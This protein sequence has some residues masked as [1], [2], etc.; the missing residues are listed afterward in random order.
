MSTIHEQFRE[1]FSN[2][3]SV[4]KTLPEGSAEQERVVKGYVEMYRALLEHGKIDEEI[5][6]RRV[7]M[8][9][10]F[11][12]IDREF[13]RDYAKINLD[14][15]LGITKIIALIGVFVSGVLL[16]NQGMLVPRIDEF[17]KRV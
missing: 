11:A 6:D 4:I 16:E 2:R 17:R 10:E 7:R 8:E 5:N 13:E 9:K 12:K 1:E 14:K 3:G 15:K